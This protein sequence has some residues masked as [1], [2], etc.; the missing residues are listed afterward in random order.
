MPSAGGATRV[1]HIRSN[2]IH[3]VFSTKDRRKLM[4][5]EFQPRIWADAV[6][7]CRKFD[8][9]LHTVGGREDDIHLLL[10]IP[11]TLVMAWRLATLYWTFKERQYFPEYSWLK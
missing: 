10:Q 5:G 8:I 9:L 1:P 7:I 4:S 2:V 11:P 6:G 3:V